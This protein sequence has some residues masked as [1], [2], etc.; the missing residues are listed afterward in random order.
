[1]TLLAAPI[2]DVAIRG[3]VIGDISRPVGSWLVEEDW[4]LAADRVSSI[5]EAKKVTAKQWN[6]INNGT[7]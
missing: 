7:Y 5:S 1:M 3:I 2:A 4:F 6:K